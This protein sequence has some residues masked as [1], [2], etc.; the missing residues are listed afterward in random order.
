MKFIHALSNLHAAFGRALDRL[1]PLLLLATR[2]YVGW[3]FTKSG[4]LK[5]TSWDTTLG[6]FRDEYHVPLLPPDIAAV[7]GTCGKLGFPILLYLGLFA[8]VGA[9]GTLF[10]NVMAVV[11]YR[12]VLLSEGFEAALGQHVLWGFMLLVIVVFGPGKISLDAW[13]ERRAARSLH[14]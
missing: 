1:Q 11:S 14:A 3:Q 12:Q 9:L 2:V 6:L 8:R 10:V 4:W 7:M 5:Y 13:L